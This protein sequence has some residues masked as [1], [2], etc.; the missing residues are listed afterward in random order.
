MMQTTL[1]PPVV[2][3][4]TTTRLR[5]RHPSLRKTGQQVPGQAIAVG[6]PSTASDLAPSVFDAVYVVTSK[7][8][9]AV[10]HQAGHDLHDEVYLSVY[11]VHG[12]K[13]DYHAVARIAIMRL[14]H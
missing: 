12:E 6:T 3:R 1:A 4:T 10:G 5:A 7:M 9:I 8:D 14:D 13:S 2:R 11:E